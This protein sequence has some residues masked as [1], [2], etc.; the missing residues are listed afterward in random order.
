MKSSYLAAERTAAI[1]PDPLVAQI[2]MS[3]L[4]EPLKALINATHARPNTVPAPKT[5]AKTFERFANDAKQQKVGLSAW[6]TASVCLSS[7]VRIARC[8]TK[9]QAAFP[10]QLQR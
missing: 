9:Q 1:L 6:L 8:M 5:I 2:D 3:R 7:F 4:S 10:R